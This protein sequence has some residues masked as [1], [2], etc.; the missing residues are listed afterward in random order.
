MVNKKIGYINYYYKLKKLNKSEFTYTEICNTISEITAR[1]HV[2]LLKKYCEKGYM[3]KIPFWKGKK[4]DTYKY[5][6]TGK[7]PDTIRYE[8]ENYKIHL[9]DL[10]KRDL[11]VL[12]EEL[13]WSQSYINM[14]VNISELFHNRK[15]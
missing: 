8:K 5:R 15:K 7:F 11:N 3:Q 10:I 1:H 12:S 4:I 9:N 2:N 6:F 13:G 14:T